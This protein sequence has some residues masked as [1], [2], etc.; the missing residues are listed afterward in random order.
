MAAPI[1]LVPWQEGSSD[2]KGIS[3]SAWKTGKLFDVS[4]S[5]S[6]R[7]PFSVFFSG[8]LVPGSPPSPDHSPVPVDVPKP[9]FLVSAYAREGWPAGY[10]YGSG[11]F[12]VRDLERISQKS[13]SRTTVACCAALRSSTH[14]HL[15]SGMA[16]RTSGT[17]FSSVGGLEDMVTTCMDVQAHSAGQV[18][19]SDPRGRNVAQQ[20]ELSKSQSTS[21]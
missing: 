5:E 18:G 11:E 20:L 14:T 17:S 2:P 16:L 19:I 13:K 15:K 7:G 3:R 9:K 12:G 6:R 4:V 21:F 1:F 10:G 8:S